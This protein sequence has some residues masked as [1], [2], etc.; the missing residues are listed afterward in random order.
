MDDETREQYLKAVYTLTEDGGTAKTTDLARRLAVSPSSVTEMIHKLSEEGYVRHWPYKGVVLRPKGRRIACKV[1]RKHRL[2]ERFLNDFVGIKGKARHD[3][4]CKMEHVLTDEA[5]HQ[6][7]R[8]MNRPQECPH[9]KSIPKCSRGLECSECTGETVP[10]AELR[11]GEEATISH[12]ASKDRDELC[13]ILSM[14]FVPGA[15][16]K[17]D[18]KI[19]MGGPIIVDINGTKLAIARDIGSMLLVLR[20]R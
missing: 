11:E 12:L 14:G 20:T 2:L 17:I 1:T 18:K 3:Q 9:G 19:P 15:G 16:I 4:A 5:E 8:M 10:L 13:R 6:L 7:C